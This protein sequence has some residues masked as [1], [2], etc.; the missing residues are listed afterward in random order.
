MIASRRI[1]ARP[2]LG[3]EHRAPQSAAVTAYRGELRGEAVDSFVGSVQALETR[4]A[5]ADDAGPIALLFGELGYP[6][7]PEELVTRLNSL[8]EERRVL[9][10][11][12][13]SA[14]LIVGALSACF[15]PVA[16]ESADWCRVTA[17]VVASE[18]RRQGVGSALM[19]AVEAAARA[20]GCSRVELTS[21]ST[22][23]GA[24]RFYRRVGFKQRSMHFVKT[25]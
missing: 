15:I 21:G 5:T 7:R 6:V 9:V 23:T 14:E 18:H 22:R 10:L 11:V 25:L 19:N 12:C 13:T 16:H 2:P 1:R 24:H 20:A 4:S 3:R 8:G 17:L